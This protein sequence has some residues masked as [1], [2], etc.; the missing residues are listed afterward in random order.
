MKC[1]NCD[2]K[3]K[4]DVMFCPECGTKVKDSSIK[5]IAVKIAE[6]KKLIFSIIVIFIALI[7]T[8]NILEYFNSPKYIAD[9]YVK[10]VLNNDYD[11]IYEMIDL[12]NSNIVSKAVLKEKIDKIDYD[13][14]KYVDTITKGD[15]VF[16]E[17][18]YT[19]NNKRYTVYVELVK[20][21]NKNLL[22]FDNYN[23]ISSKVANDVTITLPKDSK[24]TLDGIEISEYKTNNEE[25]DVY[26][27]DAMIAGEYKVKITLPNGSVVED[28]IKIESDKNY[29]I[30]NF[31]IE[32]ELENKLI[33]ELNDTL[34][35]LYTNAINNVEYNNTSLNVLSD[36]YKEVKSYLQLDTKKLN[37][38][39]FNDITVLKANYEKNIV[40]DYSI[41]CKYGVDGVEKT[42]YINIEVQYE[43]KDEKYNIVSITNL[44]K[45]FR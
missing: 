21:L 14:Y 25:Y 23:I 43:Y 36:E 27:F 37:S 40:V 10:A 17:Y 44:P 12:K 32:E 29:V 11:K 38:I 24:V 9:K 26:K 5:K 33:N 3:I 39:S 41:G 35:I 42:G 28:E 16:V 2:K 34:S 31:K 18:V 6:Y 19:K 8:Y 1:K 45:K 7:C 15:Y 13:E 22:F 4:D 20:G 30:T